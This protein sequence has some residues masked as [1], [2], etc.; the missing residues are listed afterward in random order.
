MEYSI[1]NN[2]FNPIVI[3]DFFSILKE[4]WRFLKPIYKGDDDKKAIESQLM[5][6]DEFTLQCYFKLFKEKNSKIPLKVFFDL[7]KL[8]DDLMVVKF[9]MNLSLKV[10]KS[11][12]EVERLAEALDLNDES[13]E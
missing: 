6:L 3:R 8:Y 13:D 4:I 7:N 2:K 12:S 9:E 5:A 1:E 10:K 11:K